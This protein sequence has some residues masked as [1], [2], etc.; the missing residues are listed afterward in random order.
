MGYQGRQ[1]NPSH[2]VSGTPGYQQV[3]PSFRLNGLNNAGYQGST[4]FRQNVPK[5]EDVE[6][7]IPDFSHGSRRVLKQNNNIVQDDTGFRMNTQNSR[8]D[9]S[10]YGQMV[11]NF[12][13]HNPRQNNF[14]QE[15]V[16]LNSQNRFKSVHFANDG[17]WLRGHS[18]NQ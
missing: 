6:R 7:I 4:N 16:K 13:A 18:G 3:R 9:F 2:S 8:K 17:G 11:P 5:R 14:P 1:Q 12:G 10:P 15:G